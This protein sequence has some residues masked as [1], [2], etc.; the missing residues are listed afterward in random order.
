MEGKTLTSCQSLFKKKELPNCL[1]YLAGGD[2]I[3]AAE[4]SIFLHW[5]THRKSISQHASPFSGISAAGRN[6]IVSRNNPR[7]KQ[8]SFEACL[9]YVSVCTW[10][11]RFSMWWCCT[12]SNPI[13]SN[14]SS[15][16]IWGRRTA[17]CA[18]WLMLILLREHRSK[19]LWETHVLCP[20]HRKLSLNFIWN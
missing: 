5:N 12:F 20:W 19:S 6:I 15:P 1:L 4:C 11:Q 2:G 9:L 18:R 10:Q 14:C 7:E 13:L 16:N 17:S 3:A 8:L